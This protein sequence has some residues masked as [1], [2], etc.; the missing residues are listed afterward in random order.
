LVAQVEAGAA[1]LFSSH[2]L[3][4]VE[5]LT[6]E[7]V[8]VDHGRVVLTGDVDELRAE[9]PVRYVVATYATPPSSTWDPPGDVVERGARRLRARVDAA[10]DGRALLDAFAGGGE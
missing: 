3:D 2:Q 9:S 7:V 6:R 1:L 10:S 5:D 4:V 8:I